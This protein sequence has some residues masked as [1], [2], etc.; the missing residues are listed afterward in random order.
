VTSSTPSFPSDPSV[1]A[2]EQLSLALQAVVARFESLVRKVGW[3]HGLDG[4]DLD[5]VM[6]DV[7]LRLWRARG[8]SEQILDSS[9]SYV[10]RTAMSAAL[11]LIRRRRRTTGLPG[12][13]RDDPVSKEEVIDQ[14]PSTLPG[15]GSPERLLEATDVEHAVQVAISHI[16]MSRRPVVRM[17]LL[18]HPQMEIATLMGWSEAKTRN[19]LYRGLADV[20]A[21]LTAMGY[22]PEGARP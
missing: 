12:P 8:G 6:Q 19:L 15:G 14:L 10:Y 11:D 4:D 18:G 2:S 13:V 3:R 7:R 9:A 16:P 5:E 1:N 21:Q 22:G 17:Y 20:R